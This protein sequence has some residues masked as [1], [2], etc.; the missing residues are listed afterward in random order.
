[1]RMSKRGLDKGKQKMFNDQKTIKKVLT[2]AVNIYS[3]E[4][5]K[6]VRLVYQ[7]DR[8]YLNITNDNLA[9]KPVSDV[10]RIVYVEA[11]NAWEV[12]WKV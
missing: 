11:L 9:F 7:D 3:I 6:R 12:V 5:D 8:F 2:E 10:R 4:G 1:M